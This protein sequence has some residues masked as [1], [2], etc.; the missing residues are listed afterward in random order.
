MLYKL[1]FK[2]KEHD[3]KYYIKAVTFGGEPFIGIIP[4]FCDEEIGIFEKDKAEKYVELL[5]KQNEKA[6]IEFRMEKAKRSIR[7]E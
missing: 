1:Y 7:Y 6:P 5:N 3:E 2:E 4:A